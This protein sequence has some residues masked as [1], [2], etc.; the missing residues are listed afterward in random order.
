MREA[1][2]FLCAFRLDRE[3]LMCHFSGMRLLRSRECGRC[4]LVTHIECNFH[5]LSRNVDIGLGQSL[6]SRPCYNCTIAQ[7]LRLSLKPQSER[8]MHKWHPTT[9]PGRLNFYDWNHKNDALGK[10]FL[11]SILTEYSKIPSSVATNLETT[12]NAIPQK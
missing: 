9:Q 5:K 3:G 10:V 1:F 11:P 6:L 8:R 4:L 12:V 2:R 7:L